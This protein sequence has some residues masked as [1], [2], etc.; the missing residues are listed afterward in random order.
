[1]DRVMLLEAMSAVA[2]AKAEAMLPEM[3]LMALMVLPVL[4]PLGPRAHA[5]LRQAIFQ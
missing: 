4:I 1:M 2:T 3:F 5:R